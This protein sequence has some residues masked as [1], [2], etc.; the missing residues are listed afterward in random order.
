MTTAIYWVSAILVLVTLG[1]SL[2]K[3][4]YVDVK[5]AIM[6]LFLA[7][8][9]VFN[10]GIIILTVVVGVLSMNDSLERLLEQKVW[11]KY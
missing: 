8:C 2:Y 4:G 7:F 10:T 3:D 6:T 11:T 9:P 5:D 1:W